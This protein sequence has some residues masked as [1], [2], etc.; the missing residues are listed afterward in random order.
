MVQKVNGLK[1]LEEFV[2]RDERSHRFTCFHIGD[3]RLSTVMAER[4][5]IAADV[6]R[7]A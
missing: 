6:S 7:K 1:R 4:Q 5:L 2:D 3:E